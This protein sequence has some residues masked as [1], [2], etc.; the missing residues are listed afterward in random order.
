MS[1]TA[2]LTPEMLVNRLGDYLVDKGLIS[3]DD[4]LR[5]LI[6]QQQKKAAG[7]PKILGQI[8]I[9][10]GLVERSDLDTA[11]A[12]QILKFRNILQEANQQLE[13]RV[14]ERT[15]ELQNALRKL[16]ELNQLKSNI[17]ANI[18]HEFRTPLTHFKGYLEL[19]SDE[20]LGP[21]TTQQEDAIR[22]MQK[23][24]DKLQTLIEDLIRFST[25]SRGEFTL[26]LAPMDVRTVCKSQ[27]QRSQPV[28]QSRMMTLDLL[29]PPNLPFVKADE[30]KISWVVLQLIDN[31]LKFTHE[32]GRVVVSAEREGSFVK[33]AVTDNGIGIPSERIPELFE[34]FHQLDGASTR[35]YGGTGLGLALVRQIIEAH[36]SIIRVYSKVGQGSRF[37]FLLPCMTDGAT[38]TPPFTIPADRNG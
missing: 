16:S 26:R 33:V 32:K 5:A 30:E 2:P 17:I 24:A 3:N 25:M 27:V 34:P 14:E 13:R 8:L 38:T 28:A 29:I 31:A 11:V 20:T 15:A 23:S 21:L 35:R 12:E 37:E 22:I 19:M 36:G 9:E 7:K 4:L 6:I 18:S 10:M 1:E